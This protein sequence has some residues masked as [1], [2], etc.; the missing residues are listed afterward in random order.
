MRQN[1]QTRMV[2]HAYTSL[3]EMRECSTTHSIHQASKTPAVMT[4]SLAPSCARMRRGTERVTGTG[5][6]TDG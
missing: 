2:S 3:L 6:H 4:P 5:V 1:T